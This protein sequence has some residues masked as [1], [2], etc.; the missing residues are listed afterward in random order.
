MKHS[1]KKKIHGG[2]QCG[3]EIV[4]I[5]RALA[6]WNILRSS[7]TGVSGGSRWSPFFSSKD[8]AGHAS[9]KCG[10][11]WKMVYT[12]SHKNQGRVIGRTEKTVIRYSWPQGVPKTSQSVSNHLEAV[13]L[14]DCRSLLYGPL[15]VVVPYFGSLL[16]SSWHLVACLKCISF[17]RFHHQH[18]LALQANDALPSHKRG[19]KVM[20]LLSWWTLSAC[21]GGQI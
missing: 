10:C 3:L 4:S 12:R 13:H 15:H 14:P 5:Y 19:E 7:L 9:C 11:L 6:P 8:R 17:S 20:S 18:L 1:L 21:T 2:H 16:W